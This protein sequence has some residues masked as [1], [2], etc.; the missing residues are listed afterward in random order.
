MEYGLNMEEWWQLHVS[1]GLKEQSGG[2][3]KAQS[4]RASKTSP[5][6]Y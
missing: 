2:L 4:K 6:K 5:E 3:N 1:V